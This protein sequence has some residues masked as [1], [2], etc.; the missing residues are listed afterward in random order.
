MSTTYW[1]KKSFRKG[2]TLFYDQ[3]IAAFMVL[4]LSFITFSHNQ[5]FAQ[6]IDISDI[7]MDTKVQAAPPNIMFVLDDSGSMDWE[8]MTEESDGLFTPPSSTITYEYLFD[9]PGD[10]SYSIY[11]SYGT[12]LSGTARG[13]YKSQCSA[14][15][16]MYYNPQSDYRPWPGKT[17]ADTVNPRSNPADAAYTLNL[18]STYQSFEEGIVVDNKYSGTKF[19]TTGYWH[20]SGAEPKYY[21]SSYYSY[22][23]GAT[24]TWTPDLPQSGTYEVWVYWTSGYGW[25]RDNYAKYTVHHSTGENDFTVNQEQNYGQWN[26]LGTFDFAA[27]NSGYVKLTRGTSGSDDVTSADAVKFVLS[28]SSPITIKNAHYYTWDDTDQDGEMDSDETVYLV[29]FV[30]GVREYYE[31]TDTDGDEKVEQ[32]ELAEITELP[33]HLR[34]AF[35]DEEGNFV[36]Y[37]TDAEDLQNFANWYSF[38]RKREL[39]AKA[40]VAHSII[41]L[42]KVQV[43]LYTINNSS[44][45][46]AVLP[47]KVEMPDTII[48]DNIDNRYEEYGSWGESDATNEYRGSSRYTNSSGSY[49]TWRPEITE[50]GD[51]DVY[52]WWDYW[53]TRDTNAL[54]TVNYDGGSFQTHVNQRENANQWTQL[55][56]DKFNF[57]AGTSG[58]VTVTRDGNSTGSSTSADAV[59]FKSTTGT[60][61]VDETDTLLGILYSIDSSGG[62]PLRNGLNEVGKYYDQG[63]TSSLGTSPYATAAE[64]GACQHAF[65]IVMTDGYW[66]GSDPSGVGNEDGGQGDKYEDDFYPTLADVAM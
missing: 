18:D 1:F 3:A 50:A 2:L 64:G 30:S 36:S 11:D 23:E 17:N 33:E 51:Y 62:T 48:I 49:A 41:D 27:G 42:E 55:G 15:N 25:D 46:T 47:V 6:C 5:T 29:N 28:G 22:S 53:S 63:S 13:Y 52:A 34:P 14:Y 12:I 4:T 61:N 7:P 66:N 9:D 40:A 32:G 65:A 45:R 24:A 8:V 38:Y 57:A 26:L 43:G 20:E 21:G 39:A 35:Y 58:Y 44:T 37:K 54:Y 10:M 16:K 60:A 59:M 19:T 56:I 31:V